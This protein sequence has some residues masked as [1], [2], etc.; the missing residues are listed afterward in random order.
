MEK[1]SLSTGD[2]EPE[3]TKKEKQRGAGIVAKKEKASLGECRVV[4]NRVQRQKRKYVT[5]VIGMDTIPDVKLKD[6][7]K[8]F[9]KKFASGVAVSVTPAGDNEIVIQGDVQ[10]DLAEF[11]I[12]Q[13]NVSGT[14]IYLQDGNAVTRYAH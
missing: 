14:S 6:A 12:T 2:T 8:V 7:A 10:S 9:G 4:I 13:F 11:L 1:A 5:S 3:D